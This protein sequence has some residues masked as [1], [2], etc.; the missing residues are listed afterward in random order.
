MGACQPP[1]SIDEILARHPPERSSLVMVLQDVQAAYGYLPVDVMERVA[2]VLGVAR[3]HVY[4]V[5]TF[6]R[7]LSLEPRGRHLLRVCMGTACHVRAAQRILE[8]AE[9][10][11]GVGDGGTTPDREFTLQTVGCVGACA[12]GPVVQL[13]E[14]AHGHMTVPGVAALIEGAGAA[15][16]EP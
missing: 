2:D 13:D 4:A 7:V 8:A 3:T 11:L 5:A 1:R 15:E 16:G 10:R 14:T 6:Y 9:R 12:I